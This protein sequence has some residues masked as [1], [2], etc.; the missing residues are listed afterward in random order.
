MAGSIIEQDLVVDGNISSKEGA[1]IVRGK[2]KGDIAAKSVDVA[3]G[4]QVEGAV[5]AESVNV[6]GR[7]S[8]SIKCNELSLGST[9]QVNSKVTAQTMTSVKGGK[10]VGEV[11]ITGG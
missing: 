2:V 7:Q 4:G 9:S 3:S 6:E 5:S 1:V 11:Q 8:D 10:L